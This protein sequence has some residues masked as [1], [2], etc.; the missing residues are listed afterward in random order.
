MLMQMQNL[1]SQIIRKRL[2]NLIC[3][4]KIM[5]FLCIT[6]ISDKYNIVAILNT[7]FK[8]LQS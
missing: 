1:N 4:I 5:K 2:D 6:C 7:F 3:E 8:R